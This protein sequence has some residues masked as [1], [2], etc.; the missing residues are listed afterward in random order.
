MNRILLECTGKNPKP[1]V[2]PYVDVFEII[3]SLLLVKIYY[4]LLLKPFHDT[5]AKFPEKSKKGELE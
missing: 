3:V 1:F 5:D 2:S 4:K